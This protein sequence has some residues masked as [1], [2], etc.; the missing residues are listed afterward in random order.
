MFV[1][2]KLTSSRHL[3]YL[4]DVIKSELQCPHYC[5]WRMCAENGSECIPAVWDVSSQCK[6]AQKIPRDLLLDHVAA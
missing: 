4:H 5:F 2:T 1:W 6:T 3:V